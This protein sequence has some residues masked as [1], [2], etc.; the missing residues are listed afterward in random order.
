MARY[1]TE[2]VVATVAWWFAVLAGVLVLVWSSAHPDYL[3]L[4]V[5]QLV[6]LLA[7]KWMYPEHRL[8]R[9]HDN[10]LQ[11][12]TRAER[13]YTSSRTK[14]LIA[15][16]IGIIA[17]IVI[18]LLL[19]STFMLSLDI[20]YDIF[21]LY[22]RASAAISESYFLHWGLQ[23]NLTSFIHK[24]VGLITVPI[25]AVL[26]HSAVYGTSGMLLLIVGLGFFVFAFTFE[27]TKRLSV[28]LIIH[29]VVNLL[30]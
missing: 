25:I 13:R 9:V 26:L 7:G 14:T 8:G 12:K 15:I 16:T 5:L 22:S 27:Y 18:Q 21:G 20:H 24:W 29:L 17:I 19:L 10:P 2:D 23:T 30:G 4:G 6:M 28:P 1:Y 3:Y 11:R